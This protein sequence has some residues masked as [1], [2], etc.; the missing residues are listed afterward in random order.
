MKT[1]KDKGFQ[2]VT[3]LSLPSKESRE[4]LSLGIVWETKMSLKDI[5]NLN[6]SSSL[7]E[8]VHNAS[9]L[10]R[11]PDMVELVEAEQKISDLCK[12]LINDVDG[13]VFPFVDKKQKD[14]IDNVK[15]IVVDIIKKNAIS[16]LGGKK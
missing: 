5:Y 1:R 12:T 10:D 8:E 16:F 6:F 9:L 7:I 13:L 14:D 3:K 11:N 15:D 2:K 4:P